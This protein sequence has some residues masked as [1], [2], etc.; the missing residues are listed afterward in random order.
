MNASVKIALSPFCIENAA[1]RKFEQLVRQLLQD[2]AAVGT[3]S[4]QNQVQILRDFLEFYDFKTLRAKNPALD[5]R[6]SVVVEIFRNKSGRP[7]FKI[8]QNSA[9]AL[10][11]E[12]KG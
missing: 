5:G 2:D 1:R 8:V 6:E 4:L 7:D 12:M 9:S 10:K 11:P 3:D